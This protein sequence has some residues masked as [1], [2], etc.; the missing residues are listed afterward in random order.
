MTRRLPPVDKA[1]AQ[2]VDGLDPVTPPK[3]SQEPSDDDLSID[4]L[5]KKGLKQIYMLMR[6]IQ[7]DISGGL[8]SR[9]TVMNLKDVMAML[10]V[11][12]EKEEEIMDSLSSEE[13][14]RRARD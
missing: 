14:E 13:L 4:E 1:K 6:V 9:D 3:P 2:F 7:S 8:P 10:H 5:L 11:L 12:K